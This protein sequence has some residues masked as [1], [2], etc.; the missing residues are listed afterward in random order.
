MEVMGVLA[1]LT[2]LATQAGPA[3]PIMREA[4]L[5]E[6]KRGEKYAKTIAPV[7][8][9]GKPH[10]ITA[11]Y[12]DEPGDYRDSIEGLVL[13]EHG[14]WRGRVIARD[15]KAHM[16]EYGTTHMAKRA[17]LRRTAG[18]LRGTRS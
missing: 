14:A 2:K 9:T 18:Y 10:R 1:E 11:G 6:A 12:V 7:N 17:I 13:F 3:S 5:A 16:L 15:W 8:K 4:L